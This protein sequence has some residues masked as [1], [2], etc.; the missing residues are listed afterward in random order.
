MLHKVKSW[1]DEPV[2]GSHL[3]SE[4][5]AISPAS[6]S[7]LFNIFA[8][9]GLTHTFC[10]TQWGIKGNPFLK[11]FCPCKFSAWGHKTDQNVDLLQQL[12][13]EHENWPE[14]TI[15]VCRMGIA[16]FKK[17]LPAQKNLRSPFKWLKMLTFFNN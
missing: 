1:A 8:P 11:S 2:E 13:A 16:T 3:R 7:I 9:K 15:Y 10:P 12:S 14:I 5:A 17:N 4:N 6:S